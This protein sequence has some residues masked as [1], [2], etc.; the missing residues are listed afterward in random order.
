M[1]KQKMFKM[2]HYL[3]LIGGQEFITE[4]H[5]VSKNRYFNGVDYLYFETFST[6]EPDNVVHYHT[7]DIGSNPLAAYLIPMD[8]VKSI[9]ILDIK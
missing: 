4:A 9:I 5:T 7:W 2:Q 6:V 1:S 3:T 8:K